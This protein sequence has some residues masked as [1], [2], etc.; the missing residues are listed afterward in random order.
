[1]RTLS[2]GMVCVVLVALTSSSCARPVPSLSLRLFS[3]NVSTS[4]LNTNNWFVGQSLVTP[5]GEIRRRQDDS[6]DDDPASD[7]E[8]PP[9]DGQS[10]NRSLLKQELTLFLRGQI[11][12]TMSRQMVSNLIAFFPYTTSR[13][14]AANLPDLIMDVPPDPVVD[15]PPDPSDPIVEDPPDPTVDDLPDPVVEEPP[16]PIVEDPPVD[17]EP[18]PLSVSSDDTTVEPNDEEPVDPSGDDSVDPVDDS[19]PIV[20]PRPIG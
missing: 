20:D 15:D 16:D 5:P 2:Q 4:K 13:P 8:D 7:D 1:M 9:P 11:Q 17:N 14:F 10:F 18:T 19:T 3:S 12:L 6:N